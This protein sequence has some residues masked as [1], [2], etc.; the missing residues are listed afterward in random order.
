MKYILSDLLVPNGSIG[1][2]SYI[3]EVSRF[4]KH[5]LGNIFRCWGIRKARKQSYRK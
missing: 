4:H 2:L 5:Y 1:V 3:A